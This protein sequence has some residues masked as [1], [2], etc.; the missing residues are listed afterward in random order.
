MSIDPRKE[1][2]AQSDEALRQAHESQAA[3]SAARKAGLPLG[4][5]LLCAFAAFAA[6]AYLAL[7]SG[8]FSATAYNEE[9]SGASVAATPRPVDPLVLGKKQYNAACVTCHQPTGLGLPGAYPPLAGSDWV[10][11]SEERL[12][13][14]VLHGLGGELEI[15]GATYNGAMP[16]F[17]RVPG[18]GYNWRDDQIAAVLSYIRQEWGNK[19]G[20]I[21]TEQVAAVRTQV[22]RT[23]PWTVQELQAMP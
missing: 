8:R 20:P 18:S 4:L 22:Q 21:T 7:Y 17:G 11:G 15:K 3:E 10:T 23:Q 19:A 6:G 14:V 5:V 16:A 13:R 1:P 12:I 9:S 2:S